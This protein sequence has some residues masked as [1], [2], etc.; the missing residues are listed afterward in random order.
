M[1]REPHQTL[2]RQSSRSDEVHDSPDR[3][4]RCRIW[5]PVK[6]LER[7]ERGKFRRTKPFH[8][9]RGRDRHRSDVEKTSSGIDGTHR[10]VHSVRD[11]WG[12]LRCKPETV[13]CG[14]SGRSI[15]NA[16]MLQQMGHHTIKLWLALPKSG[17]LRNVIDASA[18]PAKKAIGLLR[19]AAQSCSYSQRR[20]PAEVRIAPEPVFS[21]FLN[22]LTYLCRNRIFARFSHH[23]NVADTMLNVKFCA[24]FT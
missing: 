12:D 5:N 10:P 17:F 9:I 18:H 22:T 21:P 23:L 6:I 14:S 8:F 4:N 13:I 20:K 11:L 15:G 7:I 3:L 1:T 16:A 24:A 19:K 2:E